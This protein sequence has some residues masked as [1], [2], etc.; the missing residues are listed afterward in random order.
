MAAIEYY[1]SEL[2]ALSHSFDKEPRDTHFNLHIHDNFEIYCLVQGQVGY[3]VEGHIYS[4]SPGAILLMR[5]SETHKLIVHKSAPYER[6]VLN[7]NPDLLLKNGFSP[8]IL[9]PYLKRDLGERNLYLPS[10][11]NGPAPITY[12]EKMFS[13]IKILNSKNVLISNLSSLLGAINIVFCN[14]PKYNYDKSSYQYII[15]YVNENLTNELS[16][17]KISND[18]HLSKSQINRIFRSLT[19]ASVHDYILSKRL[20]LFQEKISKGKGALL[21]CQECGFRDYSS[22]YRLYKKR[23]GISPTKSI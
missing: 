17:E 8:D 23:F 9:D 13:E 19:G 12:F 4:L 3:I 11:F 16:L 18:M 15:S 10:E 20:L 14:E 22:F 5:K 1:E 21:A 7:F 2:F 6:F